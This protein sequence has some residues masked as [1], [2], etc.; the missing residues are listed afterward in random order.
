MATLREHCGAD[1]FHYVIGGS[2]ASEEDS[3][4]SMGMSEEIFAEDDTES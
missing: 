3:E 2:L 1:G 4:D